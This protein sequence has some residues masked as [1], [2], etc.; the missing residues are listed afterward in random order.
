M[1]NKE[2]LLSILSGENNI[3]IVDGDFDF[4]CDKNEVIDV[5]S[6][7]EFDPKKFFKDQL[8]YFSQNP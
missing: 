3:K 1:E 5:S 6:P 8:S 7:Q 2:L 4:L